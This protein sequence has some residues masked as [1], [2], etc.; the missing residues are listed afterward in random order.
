MMQRDI[1]RGHCM[2]LASW[3]FI[4]L[5]WLLGVKGIDKLLGVFQP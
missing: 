1:L 2:T 4:G 5:C 3:A